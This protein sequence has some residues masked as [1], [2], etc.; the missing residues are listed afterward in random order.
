[1]RNRRS[2]ILFVLLSVTLVF[3]GCSAASSEER[4]E[5]V[6]YL[7]DGF[8]TVT[9]TVIATP[10]GIIDALIKQ[11]A[12]P[13]DMLPAGETYEFHIDLGDYGLDLEPGRYRLVKQLGL[14]YYAAEFELT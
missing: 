14:W 9:K 7:A 10:R 4:V 8:D 12:L 2:T 3:S 11:D 1:M 13:K 5:A 6:L